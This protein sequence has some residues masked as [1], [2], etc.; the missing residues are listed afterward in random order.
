LTIKLTHPH[1]EPQTS[2]SAGE[3]FGVGSSGMVRTGEWLVEKLPSLGVTVPAGSRLQLARKLITAVDH[4]RIR[5]RA[6]DAKILRR[7]EDAQRTL[8]EYYIITRALVNRPNRVTPAVR[9]KLNVMLGGAESPMD[10]RRSLAR[11]TQ[12]E[13]YVFAQLLMGGTDVRIGEPD[14]QFHYGT[15]TVGLA[16][17]RLSSPKQL[18]RRVLDAAD[19]I[20]KEGG[21]RPNRGFVAANLDVFVVDVGGP[22]NEEDLQERGRRINEALAPV[23]ALDHHFEFRTKILGVMT[24]GHSAHWDFSG[25]TPRYS[26]GFIRQV[27]RFTDNDRDAAFAQ[28]FFDG[29]SAR[30]NNE[31]AQL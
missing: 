26:A 4:R 23:H 21:D 19:Q 10:D 8:T 29:L 11:D 5:V 13:M 20:E 7:V 31:L 27:K 9:E 3:P 24:F 18:E 22:K 14:M 28:V 17:K 6:D 16:A 1:S 15:E 12:F 25:Q 30:I 2:W